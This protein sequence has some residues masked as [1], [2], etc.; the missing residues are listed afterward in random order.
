MADLARDIRLAVDTGKVALGYREVVKSISGSE[1]K[2]VVVASKGKKSMIDDITHMCNVA[3]I[4]VIKFDEG[5]MELGIICGKPY[6]VNAIAIID[7]GNS[8]IL[9]EN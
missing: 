2:A 4:K 3:G 5:S 7:Q 9:N 8:N 6:S 1:A